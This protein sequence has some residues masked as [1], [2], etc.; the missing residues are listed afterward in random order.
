MYFRDSNTA[1]YHLPFRKSFWD[2]WRSLF[3]GYKFGAI[4]GST[5]T[6]NYQPGIPMAEEAPT[7]TIHL[8]SGAKNVAD[9]KRF[10]AYAAPFPRIPRQG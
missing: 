5:S 8:T 9:A 3:D 6:Y 4:K 10:L 1:F 2:H 7:D